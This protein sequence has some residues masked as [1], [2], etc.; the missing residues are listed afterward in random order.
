[1]EQENST[2]SNLPSNKIALKRKNINKIWSDILFPIKIRTN[3]RLFRFALEYTVIF[4]IATFHERQKICQEF[5]DAPITIASPKNTIIS[6]ISFGDYPRKCAE[7]YL[8][9]C[10]TKVTTEALRPK[11]N[12][13][14]RLFAQDICGLCALC[15]IFDNHGL[16]RF[17]DGDEI[18][19]FWC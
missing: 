6:D 7:I 17:N 10:K 14:M 12:E 3:Y 19:I 13:D 16:S 11:I 8:N 18:D 2:L 1:M 5:L 9:I 4:A 15:N